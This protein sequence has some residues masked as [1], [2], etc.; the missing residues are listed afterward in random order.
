MGEFLARWRRAC[1]ACALFEEPRTTDTPDAREL[2]V[3][4]LIGAASGGLCAF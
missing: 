4:G 3:S 1:A 2:V